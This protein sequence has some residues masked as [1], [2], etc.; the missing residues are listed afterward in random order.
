M[1][2]GPLIG[3]RE[4]VF[5]AAASL[6]ACGRRD[7]SRIK[8]GAF[9]SLSG[10]D[11][12]FGSDSREGIDLAT[13]ETNRSGG[14]RG[15]PVRI[16]YEDDKSTTMEA[17]Q[18]VRQ[19]IDRDKVVAI[20]GEVSSSRSLAGGLIANTRHVPMVTP[21]STAVSVTKG[22]PWVFRACFTDEKQ[23]VAAARFARQD[24]GRTRM[25]IF[26]AAQDTYSSGLAASFRSEFRR[27]GGEIVVDKGYQK[28]DTNFRTYLSQLRDAGTE[29][30]FVP[31]YYNEMVVIARQASELGMKGDLFLGGDGWDSQ[32]LVEGAGAELEGAHYTNHYAPDSPSDDSRRY[33]QAFVAKYRHMPTSLGTEAYDA[34]RLLFD[35]IGR[36][37]ALTPAAIR[38]AIADTKGFRG[39]TGS[40]TMDAEHNANKPI[41]VVRVQDRKIV[42]RT[43]ILA[44]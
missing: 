9:F 5:G 30:I 23:G 31:N 28:G 21:S 18:K 39:V 41:V 10:P 12:T 36:A 34:A 4:A 27:L 26:F 37:A 44:E 13:E 16:V 8:I 1:G 3:R 11:S 25:G 6:V 40:M 17:A 24:Q 15:R 32:N 42:Y 2:R 29:G 35:A 7:D 14:V 33:V 19:L 43:Q 22:R 20:L 38:D